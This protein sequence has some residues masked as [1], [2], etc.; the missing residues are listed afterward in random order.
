VPSADVE[1]RRLERNST[2]ER[3]SAWSRSLSLRLAL[4]KLDSDPTGARAVLADACDELALALDEL[5]ELARGLH[6]SVLS[7][8]GPLPSPMGS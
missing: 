4:S 2:T 5:R 3:S 1:R 8:R 6:P 7:D